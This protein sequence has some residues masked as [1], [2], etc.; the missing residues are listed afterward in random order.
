MAVVNQREDAAARIA[1]TKR[2]NARAKLAVV[3]IKFEDQF[4]DFLWWKLDKAGN[5]VD[6]GP[7]QYT[8]WTQGRV[9]NF[10]EL[11]VGGYVVFSSPHTDREIQI[12]YKI[13]QLRNLR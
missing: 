9:T 2:R 10:T 5:V 4:Q 8:T 6:C 7:F 3:E 1:E 11:R 13:R 12:K